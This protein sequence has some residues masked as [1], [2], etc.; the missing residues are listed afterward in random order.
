MKSYKDLDIYQESK[1]LAIEVHKMT[2][3]LP[4]IELYEKGSQIRRSSKSVTATIV[5]GYGR[6]RYKADFIKYLIYAQAE[7]DETLVHLDFI[8]E[9]E[10]LTEKS[11]YTKFREDYVSL[12]KKINRFTQWVEKNL[13]RAPL[14]NNLKPATSN[15]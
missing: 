14:T 4:K 3:S 6:R 5:E 15:L 11:V 8:F 2:M 13:T 12:S 7:C 1:R 10:S 9:T